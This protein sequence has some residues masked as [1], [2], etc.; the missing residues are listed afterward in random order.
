[1]AHVNPPGRPK[2]GRKK[3]VPNKITSD[4]REILKSILDHKAPEAEKWLEKTAKE[5]PARALDLML[6]IC[7]YHI[8]KLARTEVT[9]ADGGGLVIEIRKYS[10]CETTSQSPQ[11]KP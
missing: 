5:D 8:P 4:I 11:V 9:G 10:D 7:E 3:G 1:M 6:R 2:V